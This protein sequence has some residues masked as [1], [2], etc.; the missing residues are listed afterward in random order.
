[1]TNRDGIPSASDHSV[2][3]G[4]KPTAHAGGWP[5]FQ[6]RRLHQFMHS[7]LQFRGGHPLPRRSDI[8]PLRFAHLLPNVWLYHYHPDADRFYCKIAGE[9][10]SSAWQPAMMKRWADEVFEPADYAVIALRWKRLLEEKLVLHASYTEARRYRYVERI[11]TP[12]SDS[13]GN[14]FFVFGASVYARTGEREG[15]Q[16]P[17]KIQAIE[18][19]QIAGLQPPADLANA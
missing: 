14:P 10:A 8:D 17:A 7:Y 5:A 2:G 19:Y 3:Q 13:D 12:V 6:D 9:T 15:A 18:Y 4:G 1:M 16:A 11:A